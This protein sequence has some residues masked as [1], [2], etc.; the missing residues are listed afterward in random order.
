MT[1]MAREGGRVQPGGRPPLPHY[2]IEGGSS[3]ES[4][5]G[6]DGGPGAPMLWC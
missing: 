5:G 1:G 6:I 3:G 4:G 2:V